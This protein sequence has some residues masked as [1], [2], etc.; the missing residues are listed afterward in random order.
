MAATGR[1][2]AVAKAL[3]ALLPGGTYADMEAIR[4]TAG[5]GK[6]RTLPPQ[7]AVWLAAIAHVRHRYTEYDSLL[8]EGYDRDA[9]RFFVVDAINRKL[10]DWRS[11]RLLDPDDRQMDP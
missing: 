8:E 2:K 1:R 6:L 9:A 11:T 5:G 10:T 3:T 4:E 7:I